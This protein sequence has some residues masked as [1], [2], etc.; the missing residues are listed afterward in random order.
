[1]EGVD[2]IMVTGMGDKLVLLQ[3]ADRSMIDKAKS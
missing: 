2:Q 3:A 1:M